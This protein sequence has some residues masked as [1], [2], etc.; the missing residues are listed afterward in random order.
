MN[1]QLLPNRV[2]YA[3]VA[4]W[5]LVYVIGYGAAVLSADSVR[6]LSAAWQVSAHGVWPAQGPDIF[7]R[8]TLGP[9]WFWV[10]A[11]PMALGGSLSSVTLFVALLASLKFPLGFALGRRVGGQSCGLFVAGML[12]LHGISL[13]EHWAVVHTNLVV[14]G[15]LLVFWV[16]ALLHEHPS[17]MRWVAFA[18]SWLLAIH[19]H[20]AAG[21]SLLAALPALW[22]HR[23]RAISPAALGAA[24]LIVGVGLLPSLLFALNGSL[25]YASTDPATLAPMATWPARMLTLWWRIA[26]DPLRLQSELLEVPH[27]N[28]IGYCGIAIAGAGMLAA[29]LGSQR[30]LTWAL[31]LATLC[32]ALAL[33]MVRTTTPLWMALTLVPWAALTTAIGWSGLCGRLNRGMAITAMGGFVLFSWFIAGL[34]IASRAQALERGE[35]PLPTRRVTD[36][37]FAGV[38]AIGHQALLSTS[39]AD[40]IARRF[41]DVLPAASIHGD[42]SLGLATAEAIPFLLRR[43]EPARWPQIGGSRP[44]LLAGLQASS[45]ARQAPGW[46]RIRGYRLVEVLRVLHP[47]DGIALRELPPYPPVTLFGRKPETREWQLRLHEDEVLAWSTR[48]RFEPDATLELPGAVVLPDSAASSTTTRLYRCAG[49]CEL[50][51]RLTTPYPELFQLYVLPAAAFRRTDRAG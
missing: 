37:T 19:A 39:T 47:Q 3:L 22:T 2:A 38:D 21:L 43:C 31:L 1:P 46:P 42:L 7:S 13:I 12:S 51:L 15:T 9:T 33:V 50:Q 32:G 34:W 20:P 4:T 16:G 40:R 10:L 49:D 27:A 18:L 45:G 35:Q 14:A 24:L 8:Y 48:F 11:V 17:D 36:F 23:R 5:M 30:R 44:P 28:W 26:L 25:W 41:C 29:A 6:D